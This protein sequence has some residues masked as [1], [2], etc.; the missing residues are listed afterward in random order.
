LYECLVTLATLLAPFTPFIAETLWRNLAADRGGRP[1]SVHLADF[2]SVDERAIDDALDAA[3]SAARSI[4]GLGRTVRTET[5]TRVRQPLAEAVVHLPGSFA[6]LE[7]LLDVV[8]DELNVRRVVFAE[9]A[10]S[11]GRWHAK[12]NFRALGPALGPRVKE[13]AAALADDD[14]SLAGRLAAGTAV[15][16]GTSEGDVRLGPDDVDLSQDVREGWGVAS[17]GGVTVALDLHLTDDLR[18]EGLA[19]ELIRAV[20]DARKSAGFEVADRIQ[21][22]VT[23]GAAVGEALSA[24]RDTVAGETLAV[25]VIHGEVDGP[26][27]ETEID[28]DPVRISVRRA[29]YASPGGA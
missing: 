1:E 17:D 3:M 28:G 21:L 18:R 20:Q 7:P 2:P 11:F 10:E 13:V 25:D 4:V 15:S 29:A 12:P 23:A 27:V 8:A 22:G 14:G 24:H 6:G 26:V 19:R 5:K 16:V 9:S